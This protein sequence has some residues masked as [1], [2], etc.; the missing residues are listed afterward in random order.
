MQFELF[1]GIDVSKLT[2]DIAF[3]NQDAEVESFIPIAIAD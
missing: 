3:L 1:I 2:L